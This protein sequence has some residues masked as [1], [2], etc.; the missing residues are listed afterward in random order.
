MQIIQMVNGEKQW[1]FYL[2]FYQVKK[3]REKKDGF[4]NVGTARKLLTYLILLE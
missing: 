2:N 1:C 3:E 4:V